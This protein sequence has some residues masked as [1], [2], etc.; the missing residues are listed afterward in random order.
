[1]SAGVKNNVC[2]RKWRQVTVLDFSDAEMSKDRD[3]EKRSRK[4]GVKTVDS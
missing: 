4:H 1:M 2:L 3:I